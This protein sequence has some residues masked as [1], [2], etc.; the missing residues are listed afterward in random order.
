[1]HEGSLVTSQS[2]RLKGRGLVFGGRTLRRP[3]RI[4]RFQCLSQHC[5]IRRSSSVTSIAS[6]GGCAVSARRPASSSRSFQLLSKIS[7]VA[8]IYLVAQQA[9]VLDEAE[10]LE[11]VA[12]ERRHA[13]LSV[14]VREL[15]LDY[16]AMIFCQG[17]D[18]GLPA[19][20]A[21]QP[22]PAFI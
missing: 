11:F 12:G 21:F 4:T 16:R 7:S 8:I 17:A 1:M 6:F 3:L 22:E 10:R 18:D 9:A 2:C 14:F 19:A 20:A 5:Q 15:S 13:A